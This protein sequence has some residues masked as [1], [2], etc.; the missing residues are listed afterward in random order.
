MSAT[1]LRIPGPTPIP[2]A[3][4]AAMQREMIP[5]RGSTFRAMFSELLGQLRRIHRTEGDVVV[6]P[7]TGSAGWEIAIVNTLSPGDKVLSFVT[8]DFGAR[9]ARVA[10]AFRLNVVRVDVE[11][12][13]AA[14]PEVVRPALEEHP[15]A[16]A[17]LYTYNETSTAVANPLASVARLVREHGAL[18]LVD[19][20]SAVAGLPL[21]M[22]NWGV[23]LIL[24][25]SQKAW[26]CPP[27]LVIVAVGPRVWEAYRRAEFP[28]FFWD[29]QTAVK[30]GAQGNT[31]TTAPL[32]MLYALKAACDMIE[33]EGVDAVY[34]RHRRLGEMVR[35][36]V[37]E[38][39]Y[40]LFS[41]PEYASDTVTAAVPPEGVGA[42]DVIKA[43]RS[44]FGIE[45]AGGQAHIRDVIIRIGHM[46]WTHEPE[47]ARTLEALDRVTER[48]NRN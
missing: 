4:M 3:V 34:A 32:T 36:G 5:H 29:L 46:G 8:G 28:R 12:G 40:R 14:T 38:L 48:L 21:D 18:L 45:I 17:V 11:W 35:S 43:M 1:D 20:V 41:N 23:D 27:G 7:G 31:P 42:P 37:Q 19:G 9:F 2:P 22:D 30:Q 6:L 10:E 25:G 24:S 44:E 15:D 33:A 13:Q 16:R 39:G 47:L 26:M